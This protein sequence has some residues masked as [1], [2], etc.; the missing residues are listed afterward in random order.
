MRAKTEGKAETIETD[1]ETKNVT[2]ETI[3]TG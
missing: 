2:A 1:R 3:E